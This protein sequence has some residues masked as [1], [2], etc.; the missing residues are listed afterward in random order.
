MMVNQI[1]VFGDTIEEKIVVAKVLRSL[2]PEF[3]HM[4]EAIE[5]FKDLSTYTFDEMMGS[6]Q[7]HEARLNKS[8]EKDDSNAFL[9]KSNSSRGSSHNERGL[10]IS[11][12]NK[13]NQQHSNQPRKDME[14]YYCHKKRAYGSLLL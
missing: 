10:R 6:L 12:N 14:C 7:V 5:D 2:T 3:D 11:M 13:D 1:R 4:V 8:E 9:T